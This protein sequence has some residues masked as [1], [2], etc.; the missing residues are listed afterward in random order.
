MD[1][2]KRVY[3]EGETKVKRTARDIDGH[4]PEDD[5]GNAGDE[6]RK[7]LGNAGDRAREEGRRSADE[8]EAE[9]ER[10]RTDY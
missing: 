9:R 10:T 1:D 8:T 2:I 3:R 7:D 5:L 6:V 4:G